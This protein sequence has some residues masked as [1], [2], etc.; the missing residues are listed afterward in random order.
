MGVDFFV[1][2]GKEPSDRFVVNE[3]QC[4]V[5]AIK[6]TTK[7]N[8]YTGKW[9]REG[10]GWCFESGF[11]YQNAGANLRVAQVLRTL[12][13]GRGLVLSPPVEVPPE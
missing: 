8:A 9:H 7:R 1:V 2:H 5:G 3:L 10:A 6:D 4:L 12:G 13:R 11:F